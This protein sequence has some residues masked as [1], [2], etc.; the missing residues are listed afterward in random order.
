MSGIKL[1]M[2]LSIGDETE[3]QLNTQWHQRCLNILGTALFL[4][5]I[6]LCGQASTQA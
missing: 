2:H 6:A 5:E 4:G 3:S 1:V